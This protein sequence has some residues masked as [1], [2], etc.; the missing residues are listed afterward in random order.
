LLFPRQPLLLLQVFE[1][2]QQRS[3]DV[4]SMQHSYPSG[5]GRL[6]GRRST[7]MLCS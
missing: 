2:M 3:E 6:D 5:E 7:V 1:E 4:D